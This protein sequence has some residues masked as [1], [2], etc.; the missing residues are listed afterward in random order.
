[1]KKGTVVAVAGSCL[2]AVSAITHGDP[3]IGPPVPEAPEF[4]VNTYSLSGSGRLARRLRR[5]R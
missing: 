5:Q 2:L 3:A 4:Q 1:M